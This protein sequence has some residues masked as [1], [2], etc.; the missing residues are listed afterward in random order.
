M[1]IIYVE[2]VRMPSERVHAY[3]IAQTCAW[4][5]RLGHTLTLVTPART[6]GDVCEYFHLEKSLFSHTRLWTLD[7]L[8]WK[9][10]SKSLGFFIQ[11]WTFSHSLRRWGASASADVWYTR[12]MEMVKALAGKGRNIVLELHDASNLSHKR[13]NVVKR[14]VHSYVVISS[15]I[16]DALIRKGIDAQD[17][18]LAPD[19]YDPKDFTSLLSREE[20][21]LVYGI[22]SDAFVAL[23]VGNLYAWKGI[24][25]IICL[26]HKTPSRAHLFIVG[27]SKG[28]ISLCK[29]LIDESARDRV[30]FAGRLS[31]S[32]AMK[33]LSVG[34]IGLLPTAPN[35]DIG[36]LYTSPVKQFEYL[37]GG[38]PI[39]ASDLPSSHEIL[40]ASVARFYD[41]SSE[42][43]T[44]S[45]IASIVDDVDWRS[46]ASAS[47]KELV[48]TYTWQA[49]VE[50]IEKF[51]LSKQSPSV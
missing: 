23:Y 40:N 35:T 10:L 37:A 45:A 46:Q 28:E 47:A 24:D 5:S 6:T 16:R 50:G 41:A 22:P 42:E 21:R 26:W 32:D 38:L 36:C 14:E 11:R 1:K 34:D 30:H 19:G 4:F 2:N 27:G 12:D 8:A 3:Q 13:W 20:V 48:R 15:G 7:A 33:V 31:H 29:S 49:R 51:I 44:V 18:F 39:L 17:I 25:R 9:W 43:S